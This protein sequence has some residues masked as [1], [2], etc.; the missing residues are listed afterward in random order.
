[1]TF[2]HVSRPQIIRR[3]NSRSFIEMTQQEN[4]ITLSHQ[5]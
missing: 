3:S 1:M 5:S 4:I 2:Y